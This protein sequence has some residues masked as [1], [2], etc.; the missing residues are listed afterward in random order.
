M[1]ADDRVVVIT[2]GDRREGDPTP[3]MVREQAIA[4]QGMWAGLVRT[5]PHMVSGWHHH[6]DHDTAVYV[7]DGGVRMEFGPDGREVVE[8]GPGDF[9]H[10]PKGVIHREGNPVGRESQV[11]VIRA[12]DGPPT[13]NVDGPEAAAPN[14]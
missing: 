8:A 10:V 3:G 2:A 1:A 9:V 12:G 11:V 4:V 7:V 5:E 14:P 13:I 6:G